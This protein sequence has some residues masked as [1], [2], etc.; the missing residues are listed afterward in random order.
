MQ[1]NNGN[2]CNNIV[3]VKYILF[4]AANSFIC[5]DG[6]YFI[7]LSLEERPYLMTGLNFNLPR[8]PRI[9]IETTDLH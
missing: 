2:N 3:L 8:N 6:Y 9:Y 4:V 7:G 1:Y 5:L